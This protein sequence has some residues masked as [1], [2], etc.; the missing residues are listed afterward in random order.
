MQVKKLLL[1]ALAISA[2]IVSYAQRND[3]KI[4][5]KARIDS[6]MQLE[7]ENDPPF[8][9]QHVFGIKLNSDGFG[10][11]YE[12][13]KYKTVRKT[14]LLQFELNEKFHPK[15]EKVTATED[16]FGNVSQVKFAKANNFFQFKVGY[17][18][19][20]LIGG[21]ANKN[22]VAVSAIYVGGLSLGIL[23]PYYID[24]HDG[25]N[26]QN[27]RYKFTDS[28][29]TNSDYQI[30]GASGLTVGWNEVKFKP[31]LHAKGALR[32]DYGRFNETVT[33]IEAGVNAEYYTDDILEM[34][35]PTQKGPN[36]SFYTIQH[37]FFFNAYITIEFGRRK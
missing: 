21:K 20:Y 24:V 1:L 12:A 34:S 3:K 23:K 25:N 14:R 13:G 7:E 28:I 30:Q 35:V 36:P 10:I 16:V 9:K 6:L 18:Q 29:P 17:G 5:K 22:G 19:Q 2:G 31:G 15:E 4:A 33:A 32:F 26:N 27:I 8:K 11:A 37:K